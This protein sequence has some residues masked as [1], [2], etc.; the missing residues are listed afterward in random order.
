MIGVGFRTFRIRDKEAE[1]LL[2]LVRPG[3]ATPFAVSHYLRHCRAAAWALGDKDLAELAGWLAQAA[4]GWTP[5]PNRSTTIK[6]AGGDL[7]PYDHE[8]VQEKAPLLDTGTHVRITAGP[9]AGWQGTVNGTGD[10]KRLVL[11]P[12]TGPSAEER[13]AKEVWFKVEDLEEVRH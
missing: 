2:E 12:L 1:A 8:E 9:F 11:L 4:D 5:P 6:L 13:V 7:G 3:A 10:G